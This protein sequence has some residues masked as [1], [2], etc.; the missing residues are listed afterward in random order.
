MWL[1]GNKK[2]ETRETEPRR[3]CLP[4]KGVKQ[5]H[6]RLPWM[7]ETGRREKAEHWRPTERRQP[8]LWDFEDTRYQLNLLGFKLILVYK[9]TW[10][11]WLVTR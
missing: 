9:E 3:G 5:P 11:L 4:L 2:N 6:L 1:D 10:L 8:E 7:T